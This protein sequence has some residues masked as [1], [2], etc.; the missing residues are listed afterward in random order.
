MAAHFSAVEIEPSV[1][2]AY[3]ETVQ[4]SVRD[5]VANSITIAD[6]MEKYAPIV[7]GNWAQVQT[8]LTVTRGLPPRWITAFHQRG[9]IWANHLQSACFAHRNADGGI[10]GASVRGTTSDFKQTIGQKI[11]GFFRFALGR[12]PISQIVITE[13]PIEAISLAAL[14]RARKTVYAS[15][16]GAGGLESVLMYAEKRGLKVIAAQ[17]NDV[18]GEVMAQLT[19]DHCQTKSLTSAR[20]RPPVKDWNQTLLFLTQD[21][22]RVSQKGRGIANRLR[23][24][25]R[26][27][28]HAQRCARV[29]TPDY[30]P[31]A[32]QSLELE[33][34]ISSL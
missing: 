24:I 14:E 30:F 28:A 6:K 4:R 15:T 8:Y 23:G 10:V 27:S 3:D 22:R 34:T 25:W 2:V 16:S 19:A 32:T 18:A 20:H 9:L 7:A 1:R 31:N 13:S 26:R 33:Q 12:E 17:N 29:A 21:F 11:T 5:A